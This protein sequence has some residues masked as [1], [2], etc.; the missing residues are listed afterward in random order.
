MSS[1]RLAHY[2]HELDL[3]RARLLSADSFVRS[4]GSDGTNIS[5]EDRKS[6]ERREAWLSSMVERLENRGS[7]FARGRVRGL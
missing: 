5:N 2:Q 7:M 1:S 4:A 3:I 6:L